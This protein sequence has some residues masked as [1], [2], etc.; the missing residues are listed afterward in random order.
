MTY[1]N[2]EYFNIQ[3]ETLVNKVLDSVREKCFS[4]YVL[5][6]ARGGYQVEFERSTLSPYVVLSRQD[7]IMRPEV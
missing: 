3:V 4:D 1:S 7:I 5:L 2:F 6:L